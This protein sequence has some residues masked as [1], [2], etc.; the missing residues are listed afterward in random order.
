MLHFNLQ[1]ESCKGCQRE[2]WCWWF[3]SQFSSINNTQ[4]SHCYISCKHV[5]IVTASLQSWFLFYL[6]LSKALAYEK[7]FGLN[8]G[9]ILVPVM[10]CCLTAPSHYL[11]QCWLTMK[12]NLWHSFESKVYL[13]T[14]DINPNVV[15]EIYLFE[16]T[17]TS[18]RVQ[19]D[20]TYHDD[21]SPWVLSTLWAPCAENPSVRLHQCTAGWPSS[22][23]NLLC[24][25]YF[26]PK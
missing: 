26:E 19:H 1:L 22:D 21:E 11:N 7:T 10:A 5:V 15:F 13:N 9:S 3:T 18:H 16:I 2:L 20:P 17:A 14:E 8:L 24:L 4:Q 25:I 6:R 12:K 23:A